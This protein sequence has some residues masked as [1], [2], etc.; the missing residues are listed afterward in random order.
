MAVLKAFPFALLIF[1]P[2]KNRAQLESTSEKEQVSDVA[3]LT[4]MCRLSQAYYS[5]ERIAQNPSIVVI[6]SYCWDK[7]P[8]PRQFIEE[9]V[10]LGLW[11]QRVKNPSLSQWEGMA[12]GNKHGSWISKL[13]AHPLKFKHEAERANR[14][15]IESLNT[16]SHF[17]Q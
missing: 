12:A 11:F 2:D 14:K 15:W 4:Y 10:Y 16:Q 1:T 5:Q 6:L 7:T 8:R 17:L 13:R 3:A 9:R